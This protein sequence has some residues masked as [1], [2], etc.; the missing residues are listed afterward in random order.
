MA[1]RISPELPPQVI[2]GLIFRI[3]E[4][5][6]AVRRRLPDVNYNAWDALLGD[7]VSDCAVHEGDMALVWI[8]DY[9]AAE[10]AE[11]GVGAPEGA[12]DGGR[13]REDPGF[14]GD[15]VGDFIDEAGSILENNNFSM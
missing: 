12:E 15:L 8:L 14:R 9:A 4:V 6:F 11:R 5:V 10:P 2:I 7:E 1:I 3:L 13:G